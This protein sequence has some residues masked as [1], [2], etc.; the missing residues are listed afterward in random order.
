MKK[1]I[2]KI[3]NKLP[4]ITQD[5]FGNARLVFSYKVFENCPGSPQN[6]FLKNT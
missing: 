3:I 4:N 1:N 6:D 2:L 5:C